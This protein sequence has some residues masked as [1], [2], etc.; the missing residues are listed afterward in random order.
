[1]KIL[2][3][4]QNRVQASDSVGGKWQ[5]SQRNAYNVWCDANSLALGV[6]LEENGECIEDEVWLR[7]VDDGVQIILAE[8]DAVIQGMNLAL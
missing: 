5:I 8:S 6:A 1:M 7:K 4:I 2:S 3:H